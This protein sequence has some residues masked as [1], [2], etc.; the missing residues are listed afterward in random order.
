MIMGVGKPG[1]YF[2]GF[3]EQIKYTKTKKYTN[4][5]TIGAKLYYAGVSQ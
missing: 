3:M 5:S 2:R 4:I 1:T